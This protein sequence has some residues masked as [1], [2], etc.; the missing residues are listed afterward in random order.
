MVISTWSLQ[1]RWQRTQRPVAAVLAA[2]GAFMLWGRARADP[3]SSPTVVAVSDVPAGQTLKA[4]D[5]QLVQWPLAHRPPAAARSPDE[6]VG[7]RTTAAITTGEPLTPAR[8]TSPGAL[9]AVGA[10]Q[11]AVMVSED[12]LAASGL[13][14]PGDRVD[15]VGQTQTGSRTLVTGATVLSVTDESGLILAVPATLAGPVVQA[16]SSKSAAAVLRSD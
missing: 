4:S 8:V 7:R 13:V 6:V 10:D 5:V 16:A 15:V 9:S 12:P 3:P 1:R 2:L 11:V 14:R